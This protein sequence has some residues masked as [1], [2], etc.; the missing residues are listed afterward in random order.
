M[1]TKLFR[2]NSFGIG[3]WRIFHVGRIIHIA[4]ASV[5]GGSEVRHTEEVTVNQSGRSI[6]EQ[7]IL[8]MNSRISKQLDKGYKYTREEAM[9]SQTNQ[10]GLV[11]PMLAQTFKFDESVDYSGSMIQKKLDGHRCLVTKQDGEIIAYSRQGKLIDTIDH[12][13]QELVDTLPEGIT[14]DGELYCHGHKL[15]TLAS[16]IKRKQENTKKL[17]YVV[18]DTVMDESFLD[19]YK[20]IQEWYGL[21]KLRHTALMPNTPWTTYA[22]TMDYLKTVRHRGFEG[23]MVRLN[24][25]SYESNKRS[26]S[27]LKVKQFLDA[28]FEVVDIT[29]S[30]T[31]WAICTCVTN[32]GNFF[33]CSAPGT[34]E[35]KRYV[36]NNLHKYL[37]KMLTV[38]FAGWTESNIPFQPVAIRWREDV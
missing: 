1:E 31:G 5:E 16:W 10:L 34:H 38:E 29:A 8:R 32:A 6:S 35:E 2:K 23:L 20:I 37:H 26:E 3:T 14:L 36:L 9:A 22:D 21:S 4:H 19:R 11:R 18:Y 30:S 25:K 28:E 13:T 33:S 24:N 7:I 17:S 12:I 27:L 15:Q